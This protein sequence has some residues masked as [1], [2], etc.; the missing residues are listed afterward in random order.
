MR[1]IVFEMK[2]GTYRVRDTI[3]WQKTQVP[4]ACTFA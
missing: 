2:G 3:P 4:P 1:E